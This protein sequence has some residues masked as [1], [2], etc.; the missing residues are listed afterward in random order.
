MV[1]LL[2]CCVGF[3]IVRRLERLFL[4]A[5][6]IRHELVANNLCTGGQDYG[7]DCFG[8]RVTSIMFRA[9]SIYRSAS[10]G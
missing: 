1:V 7:A 10:C 4:T 9:T 5:K 6:C 8:R 3:T 2:A